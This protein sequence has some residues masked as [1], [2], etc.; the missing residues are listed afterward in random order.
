MAPEKPDPG[1]FDRSF[2]R[3]VR[4]IKDCSSPRDLQR[5]RAETVRQ[6]LVESQSSAANLASLRQLEALKSMLDR[7]I[8]NISELKTYNGP[9]ATGLNPKKLSKNH[10]LS[11]RDVLHDIQ[12]LSFFMEYM[13]RLD[14]VACVQF[15]IAVDVFRSSIEHDEGRGAPQDISGVARQHVLARLGEDYFWKPELQISVKAQRA[16]QGFIRAGKRPSLPEYEAAKNHLFD[17]QTRLFFD[18]SHKIYPAFKRSDLYTQLLVDPG[19]GD[20]HGHATLYPPP[21]EIKRERMPEPTTRDSLRKGLNRKDLRRAAASSSDIVSDARGSVNESGVRR[22]MDDEAIRKPL[23]TEDKR[24]IS[25]DTG[26]L[27]REMGTDDRLRNSNNASRSESMD[28]VQAALDHIVH[29]DSANVADSGQSPTLLQEEGSERSSLDGI[30]GTTRSPS[31]DKG[32]PSLASL[33][34]VGAPSRQTVFSHDDLFGEDENLWEDDA[35]GS[36]DAEMQAEIEIREAAPGDLGLAE[37]IHNLS[38]DIDRL[39]SQRAVVD[40]LTAKAELINNAAELRI[41]RKS[42]VSLNKEIQR[43]E[44][45][46]QQYIVQESD[47]TLYGKANVSIKSI[48]VGTEPDGHEFALYVIEVFRQGE[49]QAPAASWAIARRYSEFHMLHRRLR[50]RFASV[51]DMEFPRRQMVLTLQNDFLKKRRASLEKYLQGLLKRPEICRSLELRAF[52]SQQAIRPIHGGFTSQIDRQDFVSRIYNSVTDGMEEFFG[53]VTALQQLS[54]AGQNLISAATSVTSPGPRGR[55]ARE[56]RNGGLS[57]EAADA[58]HMPA[59]IANDPTTVEEAQ[60]EISALEEGAATSAP[61][62]SSRRTRLPRTFI[63]PIATAFLTLF[64]LNKGNA[65]WR[66][67]AVVVVLQQFLGGTIERK[68]RDGCRS[69]FLSAGSIARNIDLARESLWPNGLPRTTPPPVR[70]AKE[71]ERSRREAEMI[72]VAVMEETAGTVV[73]RSAAK[74]AGARMSRMIGNERLNIHLAF[75][76]LDEIVCAV[77][78]EKERGKS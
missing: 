25:N 28:A 50:A 61:E 2:G 1:E 32:K 44:M 76:L 7:K 68:I 48:M 27:A 26:F 3:L 67:R 4:Y 29:E 63:A 55:P 9:Q 51:R 34:L 16:M 46:R 64:Q 18:M 69:L 65:W 40:S 75:S 73:G 6:I 52:L 19:R 70:T 54:L 53:D 20:I 78:G 33:G 59:A 60:A 10:D 11:L 72:L 35:V 71:R 14:L 37:V 22:S 38:V 17:S 8:N 23:F 39:E 41:L 21:S 42:E 31:P 74:E 43:M 58:T 13:D 24:A 66:G 15:W 5:L 62:T 30:R 49:D 36:H 47:N 77:F 56:D 12:G 57:G 45:Q